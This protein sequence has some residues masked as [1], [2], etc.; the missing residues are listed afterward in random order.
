MSVVAWGKRLVVHV[1]GTKTAEVNDEKGRRQGHIA[2]QLHGGQ[3]MDVQF[4]DIELLE[5]DKL[6][7]Q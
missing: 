1:N 5:L 6:Q 4:K 7:C 3:N 2:L